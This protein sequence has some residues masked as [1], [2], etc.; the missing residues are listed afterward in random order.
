MAG[1]A[2]IECPRLLIS[3]PWIAAEE[4]DFRHLVTQLKDSNIEAIY[5]SFQVTPETCLWQQVVKRQK[6]IGFDGWLYVLTYQCLTRKKYTDE[7]SAAI[8]QMRLHLGN[9]IPIVGLL[10]GIST[11]HV[12]PPLR[13]LPCISMGDPNWALLLSGILKNGL[14]KKRNKARKQKR[15]AWSVHDSYGGDPLKTAI[16]VRAAV[17]EGIQYWRF[18]VPK[19]YQ[20]VQWGPGSPGGGEISKAKFSESRGTGRYECHDVIWFGAANSISDAESA[21]VVFT[22]LLPEFICFGAAQSPFGPPGPMEVFRPNP[23]NQ[24]SYTE[25]MSDHSNYQ[26][27]A[28]QGKVVFASHPADGFRQGKIS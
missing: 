20:A 17:A 16:E 7:L 21:Y 27:P 9:D 26:V 14:A 23:V 24:N 25:S 3:Y 13:M 2:S 18:A 15:F 12:P 19:P 5:D 28:V 1:N 10:Y 22:G 4:R 8:D 6:N 11:Q